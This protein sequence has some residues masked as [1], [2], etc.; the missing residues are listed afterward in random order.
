M[1]A[2]DIPFPDLL[3]LI[4]R[5]HDES[6]TGEL[7]MKWEAG[8]VTLVRQRQDLDLDALDELMT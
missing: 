1:S 5:L 2:G 3:A 6:F 8:R 7:A 4:Q